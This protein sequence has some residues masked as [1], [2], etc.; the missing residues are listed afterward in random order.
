MTVVLGLQGYALL[1]ALRQYAFGVRTD[2]AKYLLDIPYP[3]PP[4][5]R[6]LLGSTDGFSF[7]ELFWRL[8]LATLVVQAVWFVWKMAAPLRNG[9]RLFVCASWLLSASVVLQAGTVMMAPV[10]AVQTL[11]FLFLLSRDRSRWRETHYVL[12]ACAWLL[13][14]FTAYQI[15]LVL[16][17]VLSLF[18]SS[19][20]PRSH[21]LSYVFVPVLLLALYTLT[22]PLAVASMLNVA[23]KDAALPMFLRV[24]AVLSLWTIGGSFLLS[25]FGTIGILL[26]RRWELWSSFLLVCVYVFLSH[27]SYYAILFTPLFIAGLPSLSSLL[28][29]KVV[30]IPSV[31]VMAALGMFFLSANVVPPPNIARDV[32]HA[33]PSN[34]HGIAIHGSFGHEWQYYSPVPVL[35]L[36]QDAV[37]DKADV[38][39]CLDPCSEAV[40]QHRQ[41]LSD[42]PVEAYYTP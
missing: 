35:R 16:P 15:V 41:R 18:L 42:L 17:L 23:G 24:S 29:R 14:L 6:F 1:L 37:A 8:V 39:V 5:L 7:H 9:V 19:R 36:T 31:L 22:N 25:V 34:A 11:F 26:S 21:A 33:I 12:A 13:S 32:A 27:H 38:V 20:L 3:H 28:R 10:T 30:T 4:A 40:T 2:E